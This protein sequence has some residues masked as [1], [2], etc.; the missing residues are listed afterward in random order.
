[1][2]ARPMTDLHTQYRRC[3]GL[4]WKEEFLEHENGWASAGLI[5]GLVAL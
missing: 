5:D 3:S 1:M 2:D 4:H